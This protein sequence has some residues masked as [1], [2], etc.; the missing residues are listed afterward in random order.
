MTN[1]KTIPL[2]NLATGEAAKTRL[3]QVA[4]GEYA[5]A[6]IHPDDVPRYGI[7]RLMRQADG[8]YVPV[9][10]NHGQYI[11]I[12]EDLP[13]KLGLKGIAFKTLY[14]LVAAGFVA[15]SRPAPN[16][17]LVDVLSLSEHL[18]ATRDTE[19]W[20]PERRRIWSDACTEVQGNRAIRPK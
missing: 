11:R 10:R 2:I 13:E 8:T 17:I 6:E 20:T 12:S 14:R 5:A 9:L 16:V 19:F 4:P 18:Q 15:C 7:V 1:P 3:S